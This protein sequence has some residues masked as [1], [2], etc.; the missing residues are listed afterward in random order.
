MKSVVFVVLISIVTSCTSMVFYQQFDSV[1]PCS[2]GI[3][4]ELEWVDISSSP[5]FQMMKT[6][7]T[8]GQYLDCVEAGVCHL[9]VAHDSWTY[10]SDTCFEN[11]LWL[12][13]D[14]TGRSMPVNCLAKHHAERF[15]QWVGARLPT[16]AEWLH[17]ATSEGAYVNYPWGNEIEDDPCARAVVHYATGTGCGSSAPQPPCTRLRGNSDQGV[18]DLVG[19]LAEIVVDTELVLG[20][21]YATSNTYNDQHDALKVGES[22]SF[23]E[24]E[25]SYFVGVRLVRDMP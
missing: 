9:P 4:P 18:C 1:Q 10:G 16:Q 2:E 14:E 24:N 15:A 3:C 13:T 8:V 5:R 11:A 19:N 25:L 17:A 22:D 23:D 20:G 12:S 7:V 21:H 6:E